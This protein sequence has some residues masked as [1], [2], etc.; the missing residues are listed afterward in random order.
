MQ[1]GVLVLGNSSEEFACLIAVAR[2]SWLCGEIFLRQHRLWLDRVFAFC[3]HIVDQVQQERNVS[4]LSLHRDL[5]APM[6][7]TGVKQP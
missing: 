2:V 3:S 5:P 1:V 7:I 4:Q 6:C